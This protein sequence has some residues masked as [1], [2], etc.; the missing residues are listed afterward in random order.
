MLGKGVGGGRRGKKRVRKVE[1]VTRGG[2]GREEGW[3][4]GGVCVGGGRG[5]VG[6]R[7]GGGDRMGAG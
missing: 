4:E 2:F 3:E 1:G 7:E 6:E 5:A